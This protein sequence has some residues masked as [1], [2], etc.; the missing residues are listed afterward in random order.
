MKYEECP[1]EE[2]LF[3]YMDNELGEIEREEVKKHISICFHCKENI[4]LMDEFEKTLK[5]DLPLP[6]DFT[7][8]IMTK[9]EEPVSVLNIFS[10]ILL[11]FVLILFFFFPGLT[12]PLPQ[13][14]DFIVRLFL[15]LKDMPFS[16]FMGE[17]LCQNSLFF[18]SY[19][20][21]LILLALF[22]SVRKKLFL[23]CK[24]IM[25]GGF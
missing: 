25:L 14:G 17:L 2:K 15:A 16:I 5:K 24:T 23:S 6:E 10:A 4:K 9:L 22:F 7:S 20:T 1:F 21:V 3:L 13:A 12:N 8:E 18:L 19:I 11:A